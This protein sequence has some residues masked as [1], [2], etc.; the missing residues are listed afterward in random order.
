MI[1]LEAGVRFPVAQTGVLEARVVL[2]GSSVDWIVFSIDALYHFQAEDNASDFYLGFGAGAWS[3]SLF[4]AC[5]AK[6]GNPCNA[7]KSYFQIHPIVGF[8]IC[9][10]EHFGMYFETSPVVIYFTDY[11]TRVFAFDLVTLGFLYKM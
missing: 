6:P 8:E 1:G 9:L 5:L 7:E 2:E 11:G 3:T 4:T 10:N